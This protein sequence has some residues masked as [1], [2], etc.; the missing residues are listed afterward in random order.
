[1]ITQPICA[2]SLKCVAML[3]A[4]EPS[5]NVHEPC[6]VFAKLRKVFASYRMYKYNDRTVLLP[7]LKLVGQTQAELRTYMSSKSNSGTYMQDLCR[8]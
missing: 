8:C 4:N 5:Q 3:H 2:W 7:N 6:E 1:M